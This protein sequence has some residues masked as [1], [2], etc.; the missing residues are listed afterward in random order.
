MGRL[1]NV[2]VNRT[3]SLTCHVPCVPIR[4]ASTQLEGCRQHVFV[5]G[6]CCSFRKTRKVYKKVD[7]KGSKCG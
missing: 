1:L 7:P 5:L 6:V 3:V 2:T 4:D